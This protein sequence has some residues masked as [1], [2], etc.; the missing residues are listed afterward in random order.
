MLVLNDEVILA[1][2]TNSTTVH[3]Q[4]GEQNEAP[5][6]FGLSRGQQEA[7]SDAP[8]VGLDEGT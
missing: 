4:Q 1:M 3:D 6:C 2:P 8:A 5:R 7:A